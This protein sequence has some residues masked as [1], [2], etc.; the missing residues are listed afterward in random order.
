MEKHELNAI[1]QDVKKLKASLKK[2][3]ENKNKANE[4]IKELQAD[5]Y[6]YEKNIDDTQKQI[7]EKEAIL[8]KADYSP[9]LR[10]LDDAAFSI[11]SKREAELLAERILSGKL[12]ELLNDNVDKSSNEESAIATSSNEESE[13]S[14]SNNE[15]KTLLQV[16]T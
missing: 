8:K 13:I 16:T 5:I 11:L 6:E 15:E 12:S 1:K 9:V 4:K 3:N 14:A 10:K 7:A 2:L